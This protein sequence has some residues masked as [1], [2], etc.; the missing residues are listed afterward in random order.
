[1]PLRACRRHA[2]L[3]ADTSLAI[4]HGDWYTPSTDLEQ[5]IGRPATSLADVV[6]ARLRALSK[7]QKFFRDT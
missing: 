6:A 7:L 5:L 2:D 4:A 3:P 1:M